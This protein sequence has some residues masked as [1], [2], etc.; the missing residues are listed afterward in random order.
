ME[1][2][3]RDIHSHPPFA[4]CLRP[5]YLRAHTH[6][7]YTSNATRVFDVWVETGVVRKFDI[8]Q[9]AGPNAAVAIKRTVAVTDGSLTI[10]LARI[11]DNPIISGIEVLGPALAPP[12]TAPIATPIVAPFAAPKAAP[13]V[14]PIATPIVT[15][16]AVP[17]AVPMT[18]PIAAPI[19]A[20]F[21]APIAAP[22]TPPVGA[23]VTSSLIPIVRINVGG[24]LYTDSAG[25]AWIADA[26]FGGKGASYGSCSTDVANTV[27]DGLYC[28]NRWFAPWHGPPF[29]YNIPVPA[30]S[31]YEIRLHF[32]E[33]V[34]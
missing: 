1:S 25:N 18:T 2:T 11:T 16:I 3:G 5:A 28:L 13:I 33:L 29:V 22:V 8:V 17:M 12:V 10:R 15:P 34:S 26:Y 32:A 19:A 9:R 21:V 30:S 7:V 27:E 31:Q 24:G 6:S 23:P 4:A 14:A 20:P